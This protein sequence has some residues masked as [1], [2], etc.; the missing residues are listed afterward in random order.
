LFRDTSF[1]V[2]FLV[3]L[4][5][6]PWHPCILKVCSD[7]LFESRLR[8][9]W[10]SSVL[11]K[12]PAVAGPGAGPPGGPPGQPGGSAELAFSIPVQRAHRNGPAAR[13]TWRRTSLPYYL[14]IV[15]LSLPDFEFL[16]CDMYL[17][18]VL[19]CFACIFQ[20]RIRLRTVTTGLRM[21]MISTLLR[22]RRGRLMSLRG[23]LRAVLVRQR[24][25][26]WKVAVL[27]RL[28]RT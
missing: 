27:Q 7:K 15:H 18:L 1:R 28:G 21:P 14:S 25:Q 5:F 20:T 11:A 12:C 16:L 3:G 23:S 8:V 6:I 24:R 17:Y 2:L 13:R 22:P 9:F 4:V 26:Q 10:L 19:L